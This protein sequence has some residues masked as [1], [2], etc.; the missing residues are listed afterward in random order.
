MEEGERRVIK[1]GDLPCVF[2]L[3]FNWSTGEWARVDEY[4][5]YVHNR[6]S[7]RPLEAGTREVIIIRLA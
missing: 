2:Y 4:S 3:I 7:I 5:I 6:R 1:L